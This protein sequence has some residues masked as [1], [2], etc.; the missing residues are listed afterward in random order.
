MKHA[1][2][3]RKFIAEVQHVIIV[4]PLS[5]PAVEGQAVD[6][7]HRT[8]PS[9]ACALIHCG[10]ERELDI[11]VFNA[12][13][14]HVIIVE[15]L[16][17]PAVEAQA[18]GRVH[19]IGQTKPTYVHRFIVEASVEEQVHRLSCDRLAAMDLRAASSQPQS[20][21]ERDLLTVR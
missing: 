15:P 14:Q 16:L 10:A 7:V 18:V 20:T 1:D 2:D 9:W 5:D 13:A 4:E 19:R 12:E 11:D 6:C 21:T 8:R 17:D 3:K